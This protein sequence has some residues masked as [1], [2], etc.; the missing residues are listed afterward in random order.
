MEPHLR[1]ALLKME[2]G[3]EWE[4]YVTGKTFTQ[5]C[6]KGTGQAG[7]PAE[8]LP[9]RVAAGCQEQQFGPEPTAVMSIDT[10][11]VNTPMGFASQTKKKTLQR[12]GRSL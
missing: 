10:P 11:S 9:H 1:E 7:I 5:G 4:V 12:S 2:E 3:A 8:G 6:N